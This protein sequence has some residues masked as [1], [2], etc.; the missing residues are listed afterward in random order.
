MLN[1]LPKKLLKP[2]ERGVR[3]EILGNGISGSLAIHW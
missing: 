3:D 2:Y 1:K